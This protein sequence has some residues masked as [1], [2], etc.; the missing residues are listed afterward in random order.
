MGETLTAMISAECQTAALV[1]GAIATPISSILLDKRSPRIST[2]IFGFLIWFA[3]FL[4]PDPNA[5]ITNAPWPHNW[6]H[7]YCN[8]A[9]LWVHAD[10]AEEP[11][12]PGPESRAFMADLQM[13]A[14]YPVYGIILN[15]IPY[16]YPAIVGFL[17]VAALPK[18]IFTRGRTS[19]LPDE[20]AK[21]AF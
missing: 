12:H 13:L 10:Q 14:R 16:T 2:I 6:I 19:A 5:P 18:R 7:V 1:A 21:R 3:A 4:I 11:C 15:V 8:H 9:L 20:P 17:V